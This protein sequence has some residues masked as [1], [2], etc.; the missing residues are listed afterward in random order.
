MNHP[1]DYTPPD[2]LQPSDAVEVP[3]VDAGS[4]DDLRLPDNPQTESSEYP[5][6]SVVVLNYNGL[7][8][9]EPCFT[10][11]LELD[12]PADRL[13]LILVDNGSSDGSVEFMRERFPGVQVL[14]TGDNLGF[15]AGNN[16]GAERGTGEYVA[17]LN[18]DTRVEPDW[19]AE[20]VKSLVAGKEQGVVCASSLMLDW[21]GDKIDFQAGG[22]NFHGFGFQP[23][24]GLPAEERDRTPRE[25]L[26]ACGGSMLIERGVFLAV[27]GFDPDYFA[28]FEDVDLGWRLWTLGYRVTLTPSAVTYHRHHGTAGEMPHHRTYVLYERNALYTIYKNYEEVNLDKILPAALLLLGQRAVRFMELGGIEL[29][30]YDLAN[31]AHG[32]PDPATNAHRNAVAALLAANEFMENLDSVRKKREW[33]QANRKRSDAELFALFGQ[34]GRVNLVNHDVD[35]SYARAHYTLLHE[36][37]I[38]Q[39]WDGLPKEVLV[40]S[41]D[42]LPVGDIPASGSGIRAW[43]L[44][45][46]L[47]SRG[48]HV[49]FTMP[50]PA[51]QGREEQVPAEYVR[52]AWTTQNLQSIVDALVPDAVV[53]CGWPNLTHLRRANVPVAVDLTGPH[54]LE[55]AYQGFRDVETNAQE[56]LDTLSR[57]D[58]FTCIGQ[59]QRYYF[60]AWL[61]QAGVD[62]GSITE[63]LK[64]IPYSMDPEQPQHY[65]PSDWSDTEICFVYG[66]I[67]LPWQNPAPALLTVA[68]TLEEEGKGVLEIIGGKHPFY[69]IETAEFGPLIDRLAEIPRVRM[70][71]LL[72]HDKLVDVYT[73]AHVAVDMQQPNA[74]R[75]LAFPSRTVHY[76]WCGLP[77]IHPAFSEVAEHI[78][79]YE[80]GW[81][82][83]HNDPEALR[84]VVISILANP[85]EARRRGENAQRLARERFSWDETVQSLDDFVREPFIRQGRVKRSAAQKSLA[86]TIPAGGI[87]TGG[88]I[89]GHSAG[90]TLPRQLQR[91]NARRRTIPSQLAARSISLVKELAPVKGSRARPTIQNGQRRFAL[92]ELIAGH[93]Y[94]QR[95][96]CPYDGLSGIRVEV[97]TFGRHVTSRLAVFLRSSPGAPSDIRS[98]NIPAYRLK[99][100]DALVFRFPPVQ[101][102]ANR[103]FYLV[104]ESPDGVPG[105]AV[106]L[107]VTTN[108]GPVKGQRYEDGLPTSGSLVMSLEFNGVTE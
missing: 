45:K 75:E 29:S 53:S 37:G 15:A 39:L 18:N 50:A 98:L 8:H 64:V 97:G 9:L 63:L 57:G 107:W 56:K 99:D 27:G 38:G 13:E 35:A 32:D 102:S 49:R 41:P 17:F 79:A 67:F 108:E 2:T 33:V 68:S 95:F 58:F 44:G 66:G 73:H 5:T 16:Y 93:S 76:F 74:E 30:D 78:R 7:K 22:L 51:L 96:L 14:E 26:F 21:S 62:V 43:A 103:W 1:P 11:L 47:E 92:P 59:R 88:V 85:D 61:A 77:V 40:I 70:S 31:P 94:G 34:P 91:I 86:A 4:E 10:S 82:V 87:L 90:G 72:P 69:P 36:F 104:A 89:I 24:F 71:G 12:Y 84:D 48:H 54:L 19:L 23:S 106:T 20:M 6:V 100:G 65:W 80:A 3:P 60:T 83:L 42:V 25:L 46:G 101:H 28:F 55:R 81:V 52:G 105:D